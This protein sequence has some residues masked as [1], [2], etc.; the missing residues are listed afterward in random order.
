MSQSRLS[1]PIAAKVV[2]LLPAAPRRSLLHHLPPLWVDPDAAGSRGTEKTTHLH[3]AVAAKGCFR[4]ARR[5]RTLWW[6][7]RL[8]CSA[9]EVCGFAPHHSVSS[10]RI[11][12]HSYAHTGGEI[13][14]SKLLE[15][16]VSVFGQCLFQRGRDAKAGS[17]IICIA[18][19]DAFLNLRLSAIRCSRRLYCNNELDHRWR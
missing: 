8:R 16:I 10:F 18:G 12:L 15:V 17:Q 1:S 5:N 9:P 13:S 11:S 3:T 6:S 2:L 19:D 14:V 4:A 7:S